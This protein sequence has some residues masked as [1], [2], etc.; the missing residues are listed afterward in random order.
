[1]S[2]PI[3][4]YSTPAEYAEEQRAYLLNLGISPEAAQR[5][6]DDVLA[7]AVQVKNA[8]EANSIQSGRAKAKS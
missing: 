2:E 6:Y 8:F 5:R 1:M 3:Y 7:R 4:T